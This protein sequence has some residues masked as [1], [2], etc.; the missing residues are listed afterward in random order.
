MAQP[1]DTQR[2]AALTFVAVL[3]LTLMLGLSFG[4]GAD[5]ENDVFVPS[6]QYP[7]PSSV[8]GP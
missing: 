1:L 7:A 5:S 2:R 3:I 4:L 8:V 6:W